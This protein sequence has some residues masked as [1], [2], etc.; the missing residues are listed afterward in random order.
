MEVD[1]AAPLVLGDLGEGDR[2]LPAQRLDRQPVEPRETTAQRQREAPPQL[3]ADGV[4]QHRALV[5][6]AVRAQRLAEPLI[7]GA[8]PVGA[9]HDPPV[10]ADL[11][12]AASV[13]GQYLAVP[14]P[15]RV[16][17][18]KRR[19]GKS[20][21]QAWVSADRFR[22]ALAAD[23]PG[24]DELVRVGSVDLGAGR[25]AG[26]PPGFARHAKDAVGFGSGG[27]AVQESA[28]GAVVVVDFAVQVDGLAAAA[29]ALD[30]AGPAVV[31]GLVEPVDHPGHSVRVGK[32]G[33][34]GFR[35]IQ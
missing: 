25:A 14:L 20:H 13:A 4:E 9:G 3:G 32:V 12:V 17:R 28:G 18:S 19:R 24:P 1:D 5:V 16:D 35:P 29:G 30:L 2:R 7:V 34:D 10:R 15:P 22:H 27:V 33:Q 6:V 8:V 31:V 26:D 21:E 23:Q 11:G